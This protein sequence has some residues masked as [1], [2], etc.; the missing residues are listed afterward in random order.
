MRG[1]HTQ[2]TGGGCFRRCAYFDWRRKISCPTA[3]RGIDLMSRDFENCCGGRWPPSSRP[4]IARI[5]GPRNLLR[6]SRSSAVILSGDGSK[7]SGVDGS[8]WA[9]RRV[10][11]PDLKARPRPAFAGCVTARLR[12]ASLGMNATA[13]PP[14]FPAYDLAALEENHLLAQLDRFSAIVPHVKHR[15]VEFVRQNHHCSRIRLAQAR[16]DRPDRQDAVLRLRYP[17]V[18]GKLRTQRVRMSLVPAMISTIART[19]EIV[20]VGN[21]RLPK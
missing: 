9:N 2:R 20:R 1:R 19:N 11:L 21:R 18:S 6:R 5:P 7:L 8:R 14:A 17:G 13:D 16:P 3:R 10:S 4:I 15:E 12:C